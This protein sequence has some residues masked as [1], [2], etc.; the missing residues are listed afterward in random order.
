MTLGT[1][2]GFVNFS[3]VPM[4][5]FQVVLGLEFLNQVKAIPIPS[6]NTICILDGDKACTV[7]VSR[8]AKPKI[9][10]LSA[11]QFEKRKRRGEE[12]YFTILKAYDGK[13]RFKGERRDEGVASLSGGGCHVPLYLKNFSRQQTAPGAR[14]RPKQRVKMHS[15]A[16]RGRRRRPASARRQ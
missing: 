10:T 13:D 4:D 9:K 3:V 7:P 16:S 11:M 5:D 2:N 12:N 6:T 1:W 15:E 14:T 8:L